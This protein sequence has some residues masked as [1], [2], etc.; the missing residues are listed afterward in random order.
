MSTEPGGKG[1]GDDAVRAAKALVEA[2]GAQAEQ[3]QFLPTP[4]DM[5]EAQ[6]VL[7]E[8]NRGDINQRDVLAEARRGGGR[9]PG[10][11]NRRTD[12]F[13]RWILS[14][15][16]H[17]AVT[18]MKIQ[19][20]PPEVLVERSAAMDPAKRRMSYGDAQN[21]IARCADILLP[22]IEGKKPIAIDLNTKG[23]FN[24]LI[25]GVNIAPEDAHAMATGQFVLEAEFTEYLPE[26]GEGGGDE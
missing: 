6:A 1:W 23:D 10:S 8:G 16:Q 14:L 2:P 11:R 12:D 25:P 22:Y 5:M 24:L 3:L 20:T 19:S 4:E 13:S 21:L 15:G 26:K 18:L 17:P 9:K 7:R